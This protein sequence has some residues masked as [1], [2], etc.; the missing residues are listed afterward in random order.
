MTSICKT[1]NH[2]EAGVEALAGSPLLAETAAVAAAVMAA[3]AAPTFTLPAAFIA[4]AIFAN[5]AIPPTSIAL[6]ATVGFMSMILSC[7]SENEGG[8]G[9][10]DELRETYA[11]LPIFEPFD[12]PYR[13][14]QR[15]KGL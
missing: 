12:S 1:K 11:L 14:Q 15:I 9:F 13:H 4:P 2:F 10:F 3:A 8:L 5:A 7:T 6:N